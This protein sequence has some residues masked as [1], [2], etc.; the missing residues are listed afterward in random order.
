MVKG[1]YSDIK[2]DKLC[3][4]VILLHGNMMPNM[5]KLA[6]IALCLQPTSV[7]CERSFS[8]QNR[9][10][11]KLR[12]S[13][14]SEKLNTLMIIS[15]LGPSLKMFDATSSIVYWLRQKR[16][17]KSRLFAERKPRAAKKQKVC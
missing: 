13:L 7:E 8:T 6:A 15:M 10:K 14:G 12:A 17:R 16:R 9:L 4:R 5:A 11:C 1:S 3:K 2:T